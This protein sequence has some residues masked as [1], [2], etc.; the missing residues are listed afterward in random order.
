MVNLYF[1]VFLNM[2]EFWQVSKN[3]ARIHCKDNAFFLTDLQSEN[4]T[5]IT[6][7]V[8]EPQHLCLKV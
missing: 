4:G 3:H 2:H 1:A 6:E 8:A 7:Y 5:W